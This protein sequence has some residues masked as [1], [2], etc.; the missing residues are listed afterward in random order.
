GESFFSDDLC[1]R[2]FTYMD[3]GRKPHFVM[4]DNEDTARLKLEEAHSLGIGCA[5]ALWSDWA[6]D[7]KAPPA[8]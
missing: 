1:C 4:F 8:K 6:P 7:I 5:F 2:Y 3:E